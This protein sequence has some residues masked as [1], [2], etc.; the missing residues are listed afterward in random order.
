MADD[1]KEIRLQQ[2][3][4]IVINAYLSR[5][6]RFVPD[7]QSGTDSVIYLCPPDSSSDDPKPEL[8]FWYERGDYDTEK[9]P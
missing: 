6:S 8:N 5:E 2:L 9:Q 3:A 1:E 4:N 7:F